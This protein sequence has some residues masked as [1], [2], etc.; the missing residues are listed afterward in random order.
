MVGS[1]LG[2]HRPGAP[3]I[4]AKLKSVVIASLVLILVT[5]VAV[6]GP[7]T[8]ARVDG[9]TGGTLGLQASVA[10]FDDG[11]GVMPQGAP[12]AGLSD[13]VATFGTTAGD[14]NGFV[15][16]SFYASATPSSHF[17]PNGILANAV[18]AD[19]IY[20][21][22][23][24][25]FLAWYG[26]WSDLDADGVI[27]DQRANADSPS[28]EFL[29]HGEADGTAGLIM[30]SWA[31]P[32]NPH[33]GCRPTGVVTLHQCR[34][35]ILDAEGGHGLR[36][37]GGLRTFGAFEDPS[38]RAHDFAYADHTDGGD[39]GDEIWINSNGWFTT[40]ADDGFLM[41]TSILTVA[42]AR[43]APAT[44]EGYVLDPPFAGPDELRDVD[45]YRAV[46]PDIEALYL[47]VMAPARAMVLALDQD[48][49]ATARDL[50]E[51][52]TRAT[53]DSFIGP[54]DDRL[55]P[56]W[57]FENACGCDYGS[58]YW[59][60][61]DLQMR[62]AT[63]V[64]NVVL[65]NDESIGHPLYNHVGWS[66]G[67]RS[68]AER[69]TAPGILT[70]VSHSG[71]FHD[72][73]GD[74]WIGDACPREEATRAGGPC[75]NPYRYGAVD[76]PN[77]YSGEDALGEYLPSCA[78]AA[79]STVIV[80]PIEGNTWL[81][82]TLLLRN[83]N[84]IDPRAEGTGAVIL[85]GTTQATLRMEVATC[86]TGQSYAW[87]QDAILLPGGSIPG[88]LAAYM[89]VAFPGFVNNDGIDVAPMELAD[90]DLLIRVL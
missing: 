61:L 52:G 41:T 83:Y 33:S 25:G 37:E 85:A 36:L 24:G 31:Y 12:G 53:V 49:A 2:T 76:D 64:P 47:A 77:D 80:L 56:G 1:T 58:D 38:R 27:D 10:G 6:A 5:P 54:Q 68:G 87:S 82:G 18:G 34:D 13:R 17:G 75:Q 65:P 69:N 63:G 23:A 40:F 72:A 57:G 44:A 74:G 81:P 51:D 8:L 73:N 20:P 28:D 4:M 62:L 22:V 43:P 55:S 48:L 71:W 9:A 88:T 19:H 70:A 45:V 46:S 14:G 60:F 90:L 59:P 7:F 35:S 16:N 89:S 42:N 11:Q 30:V 39:T 29:H 66:A 86:D 21:T 84:H 26:R 50:E 78:P 67:T 3:S 15:L 79:A 32:S